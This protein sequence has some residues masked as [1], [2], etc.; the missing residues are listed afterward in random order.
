LRVP[1]SSKR[2]ESYQSS[3]HMVAAHLGCTL[4]VLWLDVVDLKVLFSTMTMEKIRIEE[5]TVV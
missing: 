3:K 1:V 5:L 2:F 4:L